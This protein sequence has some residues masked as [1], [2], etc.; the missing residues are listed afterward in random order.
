MNVIRKQIIMKELYEKKSVSVTNLSRD[1]DVSTMT[2][3]RDLKNLEKEGLVRVEHGGATL[4][5]EALFEFGMNIKQNENNIEKQRIAEKCLEYIND[6]DIIFLDA[7]TTVLEIAKL[8]VNGR[9]ITV[10]TNSLLVANILAAGGNQNFIMCPGKFRETSMAFMGQLTDAFIAN[11]KIDKMFLGVE[12]VSMSFGVSVPDIDDG[13][14]K[15]CISKTAKKVICVADSEKFGK[16]WFYCI[17]PLSEIDVIITDDRI[18]S[19]VY[20][21]YISNGVSIIKV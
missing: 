18:D 2:I 6:G 16:N 17:Q 8:L 14:T 19:Q 5:G 15:Q 7:G 13:T 4:N 3:R 20:N 21:D 10:V 1:L 12:G 11:F 9:K